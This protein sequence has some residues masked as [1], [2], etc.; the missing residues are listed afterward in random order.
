MVEDLRVLSQADAGELPLNLQDIPPENLLTHT[1]AVF[2]HRAQQQGINL[3]IA[4]EEGLPPVKIDESRMMQVMDNLLNNALRHTRTGGEVV[5]EAR[6]ATGG[7]EFIVRD[8]GEGIPPEDLPRV[9]ERFY[10]GDKSRHSEAGEMGLGLAI[11]KAIIEAHGGRVWANS[12][13]GD[14][15]EIHF[16]LP[17]AKRL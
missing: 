15:T 4:F 13:V 11:V 14:G 5:L 8:N 9:F 12:V 7:V 1:V 10:R 2:Q 6:P 3:N 16:V 17:T